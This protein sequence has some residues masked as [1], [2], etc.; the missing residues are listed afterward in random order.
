MIPQGFQEL[1]EEKL[2]A[3]ENIMKLQKKKDN[4]AWKKRCNKKISLVERAFFMD[5]TMAEYWEKLRVEFPTGF[6]VVVMD[7]PWAI[8]MKLPYPTLKDEELK[9]MPLSR[10][11]PSGFLFLWVVN[12]KLEFGLEMLAHFGYKYAETLTWVKLCQ[13]ETLK[14][15]M[16]GWFTHSN[17]MCLVG[18]KGS[19]YKRSK[20]CSSTNTIF[21]KFTKTSEKPKELYS[22]VER[23]LPSGRYLEL[24]GRRG[25]LRPGWVTAGNDF[26]AEEERNK[27][28]RESK[29]Q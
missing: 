10:G 4:D 23:L 14:I 8:K 26:K 3:L 2:K 13:K 21:S 1:A 7:P 6:N 27:E 16:G 15:G 24:F 20:R 28:H 11:A 25:N 17:E 22:I 12:E 5:V 9:V 18:V 19:Y 29:R